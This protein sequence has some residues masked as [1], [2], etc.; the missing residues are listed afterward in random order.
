MR[1]ARQTPTISFEAKAT[2]TISFE[3]KAKLAVELTGSATCLISPASFLFSADSCGRCWKDKAACH[4]SC[5]RAY[6]IILPFLFLVV[7]D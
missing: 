6:Y 2:P 7:M 4:S 1:E 5:F 3:A